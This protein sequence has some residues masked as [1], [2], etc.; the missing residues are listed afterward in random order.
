MILIIVVNNGGLR[1]FIVKILLNRSG[2]WHSIHHLLIGWRPLHFCP[3]N[4]KLGQPVRAARY[5]EG[6][7]SI[8][9]H[10]CR[11]YSGIGDSSAKMN[12]Y[13]VT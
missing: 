3:I 12:D 10:Y 5:R 2:K 9:R 7:N 1:A 8:I 11:R 4:I 13:T 6:W